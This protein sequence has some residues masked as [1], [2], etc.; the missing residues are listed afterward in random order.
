MP[1]SPL[2]GSVQ[3][4]PWLEVVYLRRETRCYSNL[5]IRIKVRF[6]LPSYF[7]LKSTSDYRSVPIVIVFT[8]YDRLV[9]M[10]ELELRQ[11]YPDMEATGLRDQSVEDS[12]KA[13]RFHLQLLRRSMERLGILMPRYA[14]ALGI[15]APL[16]NLVL[17]DS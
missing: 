12:R 7:T 10:K 11:K 16:Y 14:T 13:F 15:F 6:D 2:S 1:L 4:H 8:K 9:R 5:H 17:T 3:R